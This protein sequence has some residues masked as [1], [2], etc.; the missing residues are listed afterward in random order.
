MSKQEEQAKRLIAEVVLGIGQRTPEESAAL[1]QRIRRMRE[2][3]RGWRETG[4]SGEG[5]DLEKDDPS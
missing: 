2:R 1:A 4:Y 5:P 3:M